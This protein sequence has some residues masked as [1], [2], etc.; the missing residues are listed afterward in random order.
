MLWQGYITVRELGT[1]T[2]LFFSRG[3]VGIFQNT[4]FPR[5]L[6]RNLNPRRRSFLCVS[7]PIPPHHFGLQSSSM[8]T[9]NILCT[10]PTWIG[11]SLPSTLWCNAVGMCWGFE[12]EVLGGDRDD[13]SHLFGK[14]K[15]FSKLTR[16]SWQSAKFHYLFLYV[17]FRMEGFLL[18]TWEGAPNSWIRV[19]HCYLG[20]YDRLRQEMNIN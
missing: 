11:W 8:E 1:T 3:R 12:L 7:F 10:T 9:M 18:K 17:L 14:P 15:R 16:Q 2:A 20:K 13:T 5:R 19:H 6:K 4:S